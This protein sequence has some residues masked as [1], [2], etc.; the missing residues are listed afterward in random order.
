MKINRSRLEFKSSLAFLLAFFMCWQ[1]AVG[2]TSEP[3]V[4]SKELSLGDAPSVALELYQINVDVLPAKGNK[5]KI[6][7]SYI[8]DGKPEELKKLNEAIESGILTGV[9]GG[10]RAQIDL[11]IQ[12]NFD[13]EIMGMKW[14][15]VVFKSNKKESIKLK[16][17]KITKCQVWLPQTV[18][19]TIDAKYSKVNY[20]SDIMGD[21]KLMLYD[22]QARFASVSGSVKGEL[23]YSQVKL[24]TSDAIELSLYETKLACGETTAFNMEAKYSNIQA[25]NATSLQLDMYEGRFSAGTV[26]TATISQKY[27]QLQLASVGDFRL[28][29]YEGRCTLEKVGDMTIDAKYMRFNADEVDQLTLRDAYENQLSIGLLNQLNSHDGKY[30]TFN[31]DRVNQSIKLSG[32]EDEVNIGALSST[33]KQVK[34]SGKYIEA[35]IAMQAPQPYHLKGEGQYFDLDIDDDV[36]ATR[37]KIGDSNRLTF[38]YEYL[39]VNESSPLIEL[40]GYELEVT[41]SH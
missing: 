9:L 23:K 19:A 20:E 38:H 12:N 3:K 8:A 24:N 30:N 6:E 29:G 36:Y 32:Y 26:Q 39:N 40:D 34:L 10:N 22:T 5:V 17:F 21:L 4:F 14:S 37:T 7:M 33:F 28:A 27:A 18:M 11:A 13:L 31:I 41:I 2:Q 15:K 25:G 16:E 35:S 1:L